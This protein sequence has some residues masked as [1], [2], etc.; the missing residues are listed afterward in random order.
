MPGV[1]AVQPPPAKALPQ[2]IHSLSEAKSRLDQ[3][4]ADLRLDDEE[5]CM[6]WHEMDTLAA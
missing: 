5:S 3:F 4:V 6:L 1:A 2:R